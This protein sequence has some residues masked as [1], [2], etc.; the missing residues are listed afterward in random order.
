MYSMIGALLF[1]SKVWVEQFFLYIDMW[2]FIYV[3]GI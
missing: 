2:V 3:G 1:L